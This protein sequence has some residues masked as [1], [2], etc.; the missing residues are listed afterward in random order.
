[1][2]EILAEYGLPVADKF[3]MFNFLYSIS[4]FSIL[5]DIQV[6]LFEDYMRLFYCV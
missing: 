1:M 5:L 6:E 2:H 3:R 4:S